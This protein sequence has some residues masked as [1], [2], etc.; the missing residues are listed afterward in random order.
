MNE[1]SLANYI[2]QEGPILDLIP[3]ERDQNKSSRQEVTY[4]LNLR[5]LRGRT[6]P[7]ENPGL[8]LSPRFFA[9]NKGAGVTRGD[10][11]SLLKED[12]KVYE[13]RL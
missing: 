13:G 11:I 3:L 1:L 10:E 8:V 2:S 9:E 12:V 5:R 4:L 6:G 7:W